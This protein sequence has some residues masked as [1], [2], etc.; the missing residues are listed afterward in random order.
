[1]L[2]PRVPYIRVFR[3]LLTT[4]PLEVKKIEAAKV[5]YN[6]KQFKITIDSKLT[7]DD[8]LCTIHVSY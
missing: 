5:G 2:R 7:R 6:M 4:S 3:V 1:M 8:F